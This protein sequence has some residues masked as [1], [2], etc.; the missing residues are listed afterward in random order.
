MRWLDRHVGDLGNVQADASGKV[1][2][3]RRDRLISLYGENNIIGRAVNVRV[4]TF[5]L[6]F[7]E[8][9]EAYNA[10]FTPP[11]RHDGRAVCVVSGGVK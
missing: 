2:E 5:Y 10:K 11:A 3:I 7:G 4:S 9:T 1:T 8:C 6:V